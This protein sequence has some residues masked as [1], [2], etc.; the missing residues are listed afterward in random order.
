MGEQTEKISDLIDI[1]L[2]RPDAGCLVAHHKQTFLANQ[3]PT[4]HCFNRYEYV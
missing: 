1:V 3:P 4:L 2:L